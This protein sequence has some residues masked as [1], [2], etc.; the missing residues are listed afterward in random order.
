M[1]IKKLLNE[2]GDNY[3]RLIFISHPYANNPIE[4]RKKV[5]TI[6]KY[7][8]RKGYIPISPLHLFSFYESDAE[9]ETILTICKI[10]IMLCPAIAVYG[11]SEGCRI[12]EN[13]ARQHRKKI[14]QFYEYKKKPE[15]LTPALIKELMEN[16]EDIICK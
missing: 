6:C 14:Y 12:E 4:N 8:V 3:N 7:W 15:R 9:R 16:P 13:F 11:Q 10:L 2:L 5:D 1:N